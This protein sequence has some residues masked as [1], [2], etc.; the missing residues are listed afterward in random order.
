MRYVII[1][2]DDTNALTPPECLE[3]LY[4]PF[5]DA[6]LPVNLATI[7]AV[8]TDV[9]RPDGELEEFLWKTK[10]SRG[11]EIKRE[12]VPLRPEQ[13]VVKYLRENSGYH[14]LQ[15]GFH[16]DPF[17]FDC[18]E[19][20]RVI[21][22]LEGGKRVFTAAGLPAPETFVAPH[23]KFSRVSYRE[24]ARRFKV[25]SSGWFELRRLPYRW[26]PHYMTVKARKQPHWRVNGTALLSHPGC[27]LSY[28]R[29]HDSMLEN[30]KRQIAQR[31]VTVLVTHWWEYFRRGRPDE[32]F[33][34]VLHSVAT[35]LESA[36][37][38]EVISFGELAERRPKLN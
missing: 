3:R 12:I 24:V 20:A 37:G 2:D 29:P 7:P 19:R 23:D 15:H 30:I 5:L 26:W 1:R 11:S 18:D 38:I 35:Y 17:E 25:I 13:P 21:D 14:M 28:M 4:R 31:Q 9:R 32:S 33:I 27:L 8:A 34:N 22:R 16:H 36:H 10:P 6:D